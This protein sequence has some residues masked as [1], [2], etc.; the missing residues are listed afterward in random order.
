MEN[1]KIIVSITQKDIEQVKIS[2][3]ESGQ[4]IDELAYGAGEWI[5]EQ[6][7]ENNVDY[8]PQ[9]PYEFDF[10]A[11]L[12]GKTKK[13]LDMINLI[14]DFDYRMPAEITFVGKCGNLQAGAYMALNYPEAWEALLKEYEQAVKDNPELSVEYASELEK[15]QGEWQEQNYKYWLMGDR[16]YEGVICKIA[17]KFVDNRDAGSYDEKSDIYTF[18]LDLREARDLYEESN[19]EVVRFNAKIFKAWLL[20]NIKYASEARQSEEQREREARKVER[21]RVAKYRAERDK[22]G[23][24]EREAK[25]RAMK[26]K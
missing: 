25:L 22:K 24:A 7:F 3:S 5:S 16:H 23:Q 17:R 8:Q 12:F 15:E 18:E 9:E 14:T 20:D 19:G 10:E 6:L 4:V 11:D 2:F 13:P 21:E 26:I 1:K